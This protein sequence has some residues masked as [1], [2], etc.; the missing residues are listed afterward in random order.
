MYVITIRLGPCP[1]FESKLDFRLRQ[2]F[3]KVFAEHGAYVI[4]S[5]PNFRI[6]GIVVNDVISMATPCARLEK[7]RSETVTD[8]VALQMRNQRHRIG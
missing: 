7:W 8:P 5:A 1:T 3:S 2:Q 4:V 6:E